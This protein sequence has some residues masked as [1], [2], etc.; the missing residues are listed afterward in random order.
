V[1]RRRQRRPSPPSLSLGLAVGPGPRRVVCS[2][3]CALCFRW[4]RRTAPCVVSDYLL[5][6]GRAVHCGARRLLERSTR[7]RPEAC[8]R[9]VWQDNLWPTRDAE[10]VH[11]HIAST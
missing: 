4:R 9:S 7:G 3:V 11:H 5:L 10:Q 6:A 8:Q 1:R 2:V